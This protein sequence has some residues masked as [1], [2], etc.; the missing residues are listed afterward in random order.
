MIELIGKNGSG[1]TFIANELGKRGYEKVV[2][3]TTRPMRENEINKVDY[4]FI[5]K[6][7][8]QY[9]DLCQLFRHIFS[10]NII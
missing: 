4:N 10:N 6:R 3:Y 7:E 5:K 1:K 8:F 2:G 9:M